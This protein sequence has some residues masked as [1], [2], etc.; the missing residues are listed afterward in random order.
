MGFSLQHFPAEHR[1]IG[2]IVKNLAMMY[3]KMVSDNST[4]QLNKHP[5]RQEG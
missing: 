2:S 1:N 5:A 3:K 4:Q